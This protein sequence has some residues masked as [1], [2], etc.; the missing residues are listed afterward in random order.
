MRLVPLGLAAAGL[1][2]ARAA[3]AGNCVD[4]PDPVVIES[5][6][7]QEPLLKSLGQKLRASTAHPMTIV[8]VTTGSCTAINDAYAGN[9]L[10]VTAKYIPSA[11]ESPT[12]TPSTPSPTCT[13]DATTGIPVDI[14]ISAL[15]VSS[16]TATPPPVGVGTFTGPIQGYG[17]VVP[18]PGSTQLGITAEEAYF[19]F[20]FGAAGN[21]AP[22][23]DELFYF[24]RPTTKSTL[25]TL[26]AAI[27]LPGA[28]WKGQ[29]LA[30]S[31]DVVTSVS[32]SVSPEKTIG[33]LGLE[34]FDQNRDKLKVLAFQAPQQ[35]HGFFPDSTSTARDRRNI[36]DGHYLPW[37]PTVYLTKVDSSGVPTSARAKTL[38]DLVLGNAVAGSDVD[39]LK[40]VIAAGLVPD[41]AMQVKRDYDGGDLSLYTPA[42]PCGCS[43]EATAT[44]TA[45]MGCLTCTDDSACGGGK[46]RHG[47]CEVK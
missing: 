26:A 33:I 17:F 28:R 2:A 7:T 20:G 15:F 45:P 31:S 11:A 32:T 37:S 19:A 29:Q 4:L 23:L 44:G 47:Y 22:W 27:R 34:I 40:Q 9:P 13:V 30:A 35:K 12:W 3:H 16:C 38:I 21:A 6:D 24:I 39:G 18:N 43:Y 1:L 25:L 5:A 42:Q 10:K 8:Y 36:R 41:C 14:A 46:C